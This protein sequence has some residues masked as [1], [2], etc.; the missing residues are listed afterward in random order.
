MKKMLVN[1]FF[2]EDEMDLVSE[3]SF[4][5]NVGLVSLVITLITIIF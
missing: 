4:L 1:Y 3:Y 5:V 2:D